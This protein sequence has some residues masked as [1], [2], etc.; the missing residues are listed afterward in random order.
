VSNAVAGGV[1]GA[2]VQAGAIHGGVHVHHGVPPAA[3]AIPRQLRPAPPYFTDRRTEL[4]EL[5]RIAGGEPQRS[6]PALAVLH[7]PGG[8]GKSAL[9]LHW[10]HGAAD[11]Y[12]DGQLYVDLGLESTAGP[13]L[14]S[15]LGRFLRALG[16]VGE[17]VPAD[18]GEAAALFRSVTADRRIAVLIDNA[19]SA[20]QVRTLLPAS[21]LSMVVV[22]T[23]WRLGGLVMD[24]AKFMELVPLGVRAGTELLTR[25]LGDSRVSGE[26]DAVERLV[27]LCG[28]LPI[29]LSIAGA[30]LATRPRWPVARVV[31]DLADEQRRLSAL[32]VEE[33][34]SVHGVFDLSYAGL[35]DVVSRAY[36][37]LGLHPGPDF[38]V[39]AAAAALQAADE[40][41]SDLL[42]TLV[43]ASLLD[44]TET[45]RYYFH[46][47]IRLHARQRAETEDPPG[48]R[49]DV[50]QRIV[51]HYLSSA[52]LVEC[53][54]TPLGW[55]L[56]PPCPRREGPAG[57]GSTG[58]AALD[59]L[60]SELPNLMA[61]LRTAFEHHFDELVWQL[62]EAMWS[63]FLYRKHFPDWI[64]AYQLGIE[65]AGRSGNHA[66]RS[67]MH[68]HLGFA[69]HNLG[70]ADEA[71]HQG[72]AALAAARAAGQTRTESEALN[73]IGM[74]NRAR[75]RYDEAIAV[76][77][78]AVH[79]DRRAGLLRNE[80]LGRRRLGQALGGA[81]RIDEAV[82]ELRLARQQAA[83]LPDA[84]V[85][86][87][88]TV[89]LAD[90][91]TRAGRAAEAL[92]LA[93]EAWATLRESGSN[94][95][96][97]HVLM[98]WGEAA[99]RLDDLTTARD[100][101]T[102]ARNLFRDLGLPHVARAQGL[103]DRV[104][105]RLFGSS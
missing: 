63:L 39:G 34:M 87:N 7:G 58:V 23:R 79:L 55:R 71:A 98:I 93:A 2:S 33:E 20:A 22:A 83:A 74:A 18:L 26:L 105:A 41:A 65:A 100:R 104:E 51:E 4:A 96:R 69:F 66:A 10:L 73:L 43:D 11:R 54:V 70:R 5:D 97:A 25:T 78:Q 53:E 31:R 46:D 44:V 27:E 85:E 1:T 62:G 49:T 17:R 99:E 48:T 102:Q 52:V 81:G 37:W 103:L 15:V 88:T 90:A 32:S 35:S 67:R 94:Q 60:E 14:S 28:G 21:P 76:L 61:A 50:V 95:Y 42:E 80:S 72:D 59:G 6:G 89:W 64:L 101:L 86:A 16:I 77:R 91:L 47:L 84:H 82:D 75:G 68:H 24:G 19:A 12:P 40:D 92:D 38:R 8:V 56:G 57:A 29:A 36:R 45:E 13:L 3:P 9:A 30:R